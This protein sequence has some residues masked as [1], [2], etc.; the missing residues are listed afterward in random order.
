[1]SQEI[2]NNN[3]LLFT[4]YWGQELTFRM[5]PT[6]I[7]CPFME[8]I[9]HPSAGM[10]I[11]MSKTMKE[12][13]EM[14]PKLD[15][16]G[17]WVHTKKPKRNGSQMKEERRLMKVPQEH[18]MTVREEQEAFIKMFALNADD[19]DFKKFLDIEPP[20]DSAILQK[21]GAATGA[22]LDEKGNPLPALKPVK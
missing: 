15:D 10:L 4:T 8:V 18:Y 17:E 2:K 19:F 1:M 7:D 9:Y 3:M 12:N 14:L 21:E 11:A 16:D 22:L 20:K 6:T 5:M 13:Y